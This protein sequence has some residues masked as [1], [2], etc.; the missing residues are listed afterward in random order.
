MRAEGD[1]DIHQDDK[2]S[3]GGYT[4]FESSHSMS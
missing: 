1:A 3:D 2:R 4:C